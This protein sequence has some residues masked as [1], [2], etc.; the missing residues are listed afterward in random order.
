[1]LYAKGRHI[2]FE[3]GCAAAASVRTANPS[4]ELLVCVDLYTER[5]SPICLR[6]CSVSYG[7]SALSGHWQSRYYAMSSQLDN[8]SAQALHAQGPLTV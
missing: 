6:R 5:Q 3:K 7:T 8:I 2:V 4:H 1:M